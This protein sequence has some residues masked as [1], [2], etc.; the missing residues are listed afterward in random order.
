MRH[1]V[2]VAA[3]LA[4]CGKDESAPPKPSS[5]GKVMLKPRPDANPAAAGVTQ[6]ARDDAAA[7]RDLRTA[8]S[9]DDAQSARRHWCRAI[10]AWPTAVQTPLPDASVLAGLTIEL[11]DGA[12]AEE[13]FAK[14]LSLSVLAL[15]DD[16]G[17]RHAKI[18]QVRPSN[19]DQATMVLEA[20]A[21]LILLFKG[22]GDAAVISPDLMAHLDTLPAQASYVLAP[23]ERGW[24]WKDLSSAELR[25]TPDGWW[26]AVATPPGGGGRWI[27]IFTDR[28]T[29]PPK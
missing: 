9:C 7:L 11:A 19:N 13:A 4:A 2:V 22:N 6:G 10:D 18:T 20:M 12:A 28:L 29:G 14:H 8:S 21:N 1:L 17:R 23:T 27:S 25:Q 24:A 26:I 5:S 15:R 3:L 16:A